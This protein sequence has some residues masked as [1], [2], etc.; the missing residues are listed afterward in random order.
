MGKLNKTESLR[1]RVAQAIRRREAKGWHV[2]EDVKRNV[3]TKGY[4]YLKSLHDNKYR[5]L[6]E[7]STT[8]DE[9]TGEKITGQQATVRQ[10]WS[11]ESRVE[12]YNR[13]IMNRMRQN[14]EF[15][16]AFSEGTILSERITDLINQFY[17]NDDPHAGVL[18]D[19][20]QRAID[21]VGDEGY[22]AAL[23][24]YAGRIMDDISLA[25]KYRHG[26]S[27]HDD[28]VDDLI[29]LISGLSWSDEDRRFYATDSASYGD[30]FDEFQP[31]TFDDL[32][33]IAEQYKTMASDMGILQ[34]P[35]A[36]D[37]VRRGRERSGNKWVV[38]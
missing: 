6:N 32:I 4:Q 30:M 1:R 11:I 33:N 12:Q 16:K 22:R 27:Y 36:S 35:D 23:A 18:D 15:Q 31:T 14:P 3:E 9:V 24:D 13:S 28:A 37:V 5:K 7:A 8:I 25:L 20:V 34:M 2:D 38:I 29:D 19:A 10:R 26:L 17:A 21:T